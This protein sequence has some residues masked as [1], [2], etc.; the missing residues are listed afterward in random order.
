MTL[1]KSSPDD[2]VEFSKLTNGHIDLYIVD[3]S[4]VS[5]LWA[6]LDAGDPTARCIWR[7]V[8]Q[9]LR[10]VRRVKRGHGPLCLDCETEFHKTS[11]LPGAFM[12]VVPFANP[13]AA[14]VTAICETCTATKNLN[15]AS[16]RAVRQI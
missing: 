10:H 16:L 15:A 3:S 13:A 11:E 2:F 5:K 12:V 9:L 1:F 6:A 8:D 14:M 7:A 4:S